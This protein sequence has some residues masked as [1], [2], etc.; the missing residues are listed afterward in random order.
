M[1]KSSFCSFGEGFIGIDEV[2][3]GSWCGPVVACSILLHE[4][5]FNNDFSKSID[6]SKKIKKN[7]REFLSS[8]IKKNSHYNFG[9]SDSKEIDRFG[10]LK[11]TELAMK[12]SFYPFKNYNNKVII[13]GPKFFFLNKNAEFI[14]KGDQKFK[15]ISA[16]SILA[17][18]YRDNLMKRL[19]IKYPKYGWNQNFGYG[20]E[21]HK[22]AL[23]KYGITP[24]HRATFNPMLK[25]ISDSKVKEEE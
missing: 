2:G 24:E 25:I 8:Q 12:R 4:N 21:L 18:V 13:D 16:A 20:T 7:N 14:V 1:I 15:V 9:L 5:F 22:N 17:K 19:S 3:R 11:A 10:I 6:D 23:N